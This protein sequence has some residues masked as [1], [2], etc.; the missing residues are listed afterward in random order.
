MYWQVKI[1]QSASWFQSGIPKSNYRHCFCSNWKDSLLSIV[2]SLIGLEMTR[3]SF[4]RDLSLVRSFPWCLTS[5]LCWPG[6]CHRVTCAVSLSASALWW[7]FLFCSWN[8][9]LGLR[10]SFLFC[11]PRSGKGWAPF[12]NSLESVMYSL[13][14][15]FPVDSKSSCW[16]FSREGD[17]E[18]L[19]LLPP[20]SL[21]ISL[22]FKASPKC[23]CIRKSCLKTSLEHF[24]FSQKVTE[25]LPTVPCVWPGVGWWISGSSPSRQHLQSPESLTMGIFLL[26]AS[27]LLPGQPSVRLQVL[28]YFKVN[29]QI[30]KIFI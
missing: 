13:T 8:Q 20:G 16:C 4:P 21:S 17:S 9:S 7:S 30:L 12:S 28:F 25:E 27:S 26:N 1:T 3:P 19:S 22:S 23:V 29:F 6:H 15:L 24:L 5:A 18:S 11:S 2:L 10:V 14:L